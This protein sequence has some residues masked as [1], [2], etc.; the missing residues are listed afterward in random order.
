MMVKGFAEAWAFCRN[1]HSA[2]QNMSARQRHRRIDVERRN[3]FQLWPVGSI[4][5]G[6]GERPLRGMKAFPW[7]RLSDRCQFRHY[8][9]GPWPAARPDVQ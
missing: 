8:V 2:R 4:I 9:R 1:P 7:P 6:S 3:P 5:A